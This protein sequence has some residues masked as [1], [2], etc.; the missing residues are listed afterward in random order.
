[1][2]VE[3]QKA[4]GRIRR[5]Q[6]RNVDTMLVCDEL[7]RFLIDPLYRVVIEP[8]REIDVGVEATS[9]CPV[10]DA[11]RQANRARVQRHRKRKT[12]DAE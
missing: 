8:E 12:K 3:I 2:S 1:M 6:G 10:C 4:I 9:H 7:E 5:T 11:R